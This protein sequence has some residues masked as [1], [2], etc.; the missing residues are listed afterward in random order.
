MPSYLKESEGDC[1][2]KYGF[3]LWAKYGS[4]AGTREERL[5]SCIN[6]SSLKTPSAG[7]A[8]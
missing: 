4:E 8:P 2:Y 3:H 7:P 1:F 5:F 6:S